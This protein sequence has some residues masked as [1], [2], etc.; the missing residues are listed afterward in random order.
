MMKPRPT[1][2]KKPI[3]SIKMQKLKIAVKFHNVRNTHQLLQKQGFCGQVVDL[4]IPGMTVSLNLAC[5]TST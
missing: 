4:T 1:M 2:K 3:Y 5:E